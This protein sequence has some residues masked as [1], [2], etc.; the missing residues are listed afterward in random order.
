VAATVRTTGRPQTFCHKT[1]CDRGQTYDKPEGEIDA[2]GHENHRHSENSDGRDCGLPDDDGGVV[3]GSE[4][5]DEDDS[6]KHQEDQD[7]STP[8]F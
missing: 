2:T 7:G 1:G 5:A 8:V 6:K 4:V 3:D